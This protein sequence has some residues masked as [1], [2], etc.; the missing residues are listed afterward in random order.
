MKCIFAV[1][2]LVAA[3]SA[4]E[5]TTTAFNYHEQIGIHEA[6]RI[7]Q[8]EAAMDF[9]G[10]RIVGGSPS[11]VGNHP[12]VAGLVITLTSGWQSVC[13]ASLLTNNRIVTAAHCWWDGRNQA[14]QFV[15]VLGVA[16]LF[17]G[18]VRI[19]TNNVRMH[20]SWNPSNANNDV[21][22]AVINWVGYTNV[23]Q[24]IALAS[25][26]QDYVGTWATAAGYGRTSQSGIPA[27]QVR[28]E[29][30]LRVITNVEC[31]NTFSSSIVVAST[32]CTSGQ[33]GVGTCGGD[34]GGPLAIGS[35]NSRILIG[36]TSF[37]SPRG[38]QVGFP[39]G[40]GRVTSFNSWIRG[41]L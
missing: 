13:T 40:F 25:G 22:V 7:K 24:A 10:S 38:C 1:L 16:T 11:A 17:T 12:H 26:N 8:A 37:G 27:N 15:V 35:G 21:A 2:C 9:D 29:V 19:T 32:L 31:R 5:I 41:N 23:I 4:N 20:Q 39:A 33:G 18:G 3:A 6:A 28:H 34:S 36:I 30:N 14:R